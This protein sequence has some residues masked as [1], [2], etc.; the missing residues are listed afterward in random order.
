M[1]AFTAPAQ[2]ALPGLPLVLATASDGSLHA[3]IAGTG[4]RSWVLLSGASGECSGPAVDGAGRVAFAGGPGSALF[5][6]PPGVVPPAAGGGGVLARQPGAPGAGGRWSGLAMGP[7]GDGGAAAVVAVDGTTGQLL[8]LN[9]TLGVVWSWALP[10]GAAPCAT[11]LLDAGGATVLLNCGGTGTLYAVEGATGVALWSVSTG[12]PGAPGAAPPAPPVL[13]ADGVLLVPSADGALVCL[14]DSWTALRPF[15]WAPGPPPIESAVSVTAAAL[16]ISLGA[17]ALLLAFATRRYA[18]SHWPLTAPPAPPPPQPPL[19]PPPQPVEN[20]LA[21]KERAEAEAHKQRLEP[22][23]SFR[24][25]LFAA[26]MVGSFQRAREVPP[27]AP[28]PAPAPPTPRSAKPLPP[29]IHV[30]PPA[31]APG[32]EPAAPPTLT[33]P[34]KNKEPPLPPWLHVSQRL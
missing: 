22:Q 3:V 18:A 23:P 8:A 17:C 1:G 9:A 10:S 19:P 6:V 16:M 21:A 20:P 29:W 12:A 30:P 15:G 13:A 2:G 33:A 28:P 5:L 25:A 4:L 32:P 11:P 34:L 26:G 7:L 24:D 31:P 14:V 27:P